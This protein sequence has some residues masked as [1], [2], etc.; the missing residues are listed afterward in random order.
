[1][2]AA[3]LTH[4]G[5]YRH[6]ASK[7]ELVAEACKKAFA[8]LLDKLELLSE[9]ANDTAL[10]ALV[11][12]YLSPRHRDGYEQACPLAAL[13]SELRLV[14]GQTRDVSIAG[15]NRLVGIVAGTLNDVSPH[16]A[17]ARA[18]AIVSAMVG[19]M[20]LARI[21]DSQSV[22]NKVLKDTREWILSTQ[23]NNR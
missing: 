13:G 7:D 19:S 9:Q 14:D 2:A 6:F 11:N 22:S 16:E 17:Q 1:M 3:G 8:T 21:V 18:T 12:A 23:T 10:A 20:V 5:F 4:G 15:L